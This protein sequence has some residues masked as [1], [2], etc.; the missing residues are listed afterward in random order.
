M[1]RW[2]TGRPQGV[3]NNLPTDNICYGAQSRKH[4]LA[5][6]FTPFDPKRQSYLGWLTENLCSVLH[7]TSP[8]WAPAGLDAK[9]C[10]RIGFVRHRLKKL[11][12]KAAVAFNF[13]LARAIE[14]N[15]NEAA[16]PLWAFGEP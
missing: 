4:M 6:R 5:V 15:P 1:V 11:K 13:G 10:R 8:K 9:S 14:P 2:A 12:S 3:P 7:S 16:S